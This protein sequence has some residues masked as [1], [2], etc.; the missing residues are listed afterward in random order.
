[1]K[2]VVTVLVC[3]ALSAICTCG[4]V[5]ASEE[6][7]YGKWV[8]LNSGSELTL[9]SSWYSINKHNIATSSWWEQTGNTICLHGDPQQTLDIVT[10]DD[11]T[12]L[13]NDTCSYYRMEDLPAPEL[14]V[15]EQGECGDVL[16]SVKNVEF[17]RELPENVYSILRYKSD[18]LELDDGQ[19]Y[20]SATYELTNNSN[21]PIIVGSV[22]HNVELTVIYDDGFL[23][24]TEDE[25]TDIFA[26]DDT[27]N[28]YY[29]RGSYGNPIEVQPLSTKKVSTFIK[30]PEV[31]ESNAE[32]PLNIMFGLFFNEK[33][34][35]Y[36]YNCR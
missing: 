35:L 29:N 7:L 14:S 25:A 13:S 30:V 21:L 31:L 2:R 8:D 22:D 18:E 3:G 16:F 36:K 4:I 27:A 32:T 6:D 17:T 24:S 10:A 12:S 23:F 9:E 19:V 11:I 34:Q 5:F 15:D 20:I 1:M 26:S 33:A 28:L